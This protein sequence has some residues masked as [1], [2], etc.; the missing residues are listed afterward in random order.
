VVR[1]E[2]DNRLKG[3][4]RRKIWLEG[5]AEPMTLE[6]RPTPDRTLAVCLLKFTNPL[7]RM[8]S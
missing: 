6:S 3:V 1:G 8:A 5:R 4:V 2:I 7:K